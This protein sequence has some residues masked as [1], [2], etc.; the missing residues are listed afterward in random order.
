[1]IEIYTLD[2]PVLRSKPQQVTEFNSSLGDVLDEM[3]R[4]MLRANGIG[5]AATQVGFPYAVA[6]MKNGDDVI[7]LINPE[8]WDGDEPVLMEEGCLSI[9]GFMDRVTRWVNVR[10]IAQNRHGTLMQFEC[11]GLPSQIIQHE[12][13]HLNGVLFVDRLI[14]DRKWRVWLED[15]RD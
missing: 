3:T 2:H 15:A 7:D 9:P 8:I 11:S 6:I 12:V 1:M 5:L 10:G 14:D 4:T 13:D